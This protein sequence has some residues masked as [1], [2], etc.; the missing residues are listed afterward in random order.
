MR[1]IAWEFA[2][3]TAALFGLWLVILFAMVEFGL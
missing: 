3:A 1:T 2:K